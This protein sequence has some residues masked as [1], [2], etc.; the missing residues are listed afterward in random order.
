MSRLSTIAITSIGSLVGSAIL[1]SIEHRHDGFQIIGY[2]S[3]A[4][5]VNNFRADKTFLLPPAAELNAYRA[6]LTSR[7]TLDRPDIV[8][9]GRDEDV[10]I[11]AALR[12][13]GNFGE[14]TIVAP[15]PAVATVLSDKFETYRFA[16]TN[17]LAFARTAIDRKGA[18]D[19]VR[20]TGFP[21]IVKLR[22]GGHA[23]RNVFIC[24]NAEELDHA[25]NSGDAY[26]FQEFLA[27]PDRLSDTLPNFAFG[28]PLFFAYAEKTQYSAQLLLAENGAV[29]SQ[30]SVISHFEQ[31]RS[32]R[33]EPVDEPGLDEIGRGYARALAG[34]GFFGPLNVQCK[35][36]DDGSFVCFELNGR[37]VG[38]TYA[39]ALLGYR[40]V[41]FLLDYITS[42]A[43]PLAGPYADPGAV[44]IRPPSSVLMNT[45]AVAA[46][47][48]TGSWAR[49][50]DTS[51]AS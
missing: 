30:F 51:S 22:I 42:G 3:T 14:T 28:V 48:E 7:L 16:S 10:G 23:S 25:L 41:E 26:L 31:G 45:A 21:I 33:V 1:D 29:I 9:A 46:L 37:F 18:E 15:S 6:A 17:G 32:I 34:L 8:L 4:E 12:E 49:H 2:N 40:E 38:G 50:P 39:R 43:R 44:V 19:L 20:D 13:D 5:A 36:L 35:K 27:R 47:S 11:L 24:R